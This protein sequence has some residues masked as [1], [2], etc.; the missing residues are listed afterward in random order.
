MYTQHTPRKVG[1]E[2]NYKVAHYIQSTK[3][4]SYGGWV[5]R[6]VMEDATKATA[7]LSVT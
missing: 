6:S 4:K 3:L 7:R 5:E 2:Q 1:H